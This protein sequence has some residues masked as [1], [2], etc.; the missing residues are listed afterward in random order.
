[1]RTPAARS[2]W[3]RYVPIF[4]DEHH[5]YFVE[6]TMRRGA[7]NLNLY[8]WFTENKPDALQAPRRPFGAQSQQR[9][10]RRRAAVLL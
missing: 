3:R 7:L 10:R 1:M 5:V 2:A 6:Y 8:A 9:S 4:E